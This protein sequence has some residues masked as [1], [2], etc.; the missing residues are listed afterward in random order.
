[1]EVRP[2]DAAL[3]WELAEDQ[4]ERTGIALTPPLLS[5]DECAD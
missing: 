1:M 2:R 3:D 4:L 5:P